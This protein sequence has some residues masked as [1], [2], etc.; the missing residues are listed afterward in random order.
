VA[1]T[2]DLTLFLQDFGVTCIAGSVTALGILDMP[3]QVVADGVILSTDYGLTCRAVDFGGLL[4]G[5]GITVDGINYQVRE[6][7]LL[8]DGA[9]VEISLERLAPTSNA[10]GQNPRTFGLSDLTDVNVTGAAPGDQLTYNG[11][12]W[13]DA[14]APKSITIANPVSGDNFTLFRTEV[15]TTLS[16]VYAVVRGSNPSVTF[17]LKSDPNR[18]TEGTPATVSEAITNTTTGEEVAVINQPIGAGRYVWLEVTGTGG[19]VTELNV[20]VEI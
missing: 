4:Y 12:E 13:V 5:D 6:T 17:V 19:V 14:G 9:F 20:S 7:R 3:S 2:E 1:F 16:K 15:P 8:D 11:S 10:P 18:S